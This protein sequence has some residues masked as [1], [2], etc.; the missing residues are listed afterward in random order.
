MIIF[1]S[2]NS[3][4]TH[5]QRLIVILESF[6]F[7]VKKFFVQLCAERSIGKLFGMP[8]SPKKVGLYLKALGLLLLIGSVI[9]YLVYQTVSGGKGALAVEATPVAL[10]YVNGEQKGKTP[11]EVELAAKEIIL[12]LVPENKALLPY[13]TKLKLVEGVKTI[14]RR[15]FGESGELSSTQIISFEKSLESKAQIAVVTIPDRAE[16]VVDNVPKG[17]TPINFSTSSGKHTVRIS[18]PG[19]IDQELLVEA[20]SGYIVTIIIDMA[21]EYV[22]TPP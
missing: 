10:V 21:Q 14:V 6:Y 16:V 18:L 3:I 13:E 22:A 19:F 9:G 1:T 7:V 8:S 2:E 17:P 20:I 11:L 5:K 4:I 12:T 15:E